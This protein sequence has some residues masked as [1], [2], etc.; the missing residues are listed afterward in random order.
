MGI[1]VVK[2]LKE[3]Y[4]FQLYSKDF[5]VLQVL[6]DGATVSNKALKYVLNTNNKIIYLVA[7][8]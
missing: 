2:G 5:G 1:Y 4:R 7:V 6:T 3:A 8:Q